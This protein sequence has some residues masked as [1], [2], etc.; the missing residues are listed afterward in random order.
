MNRA[1]ALALLRSQNPRERLEAARTLTRAA[2]QAD[3]P[4][5]REALRQ[6]RVGWIRQ[7]LEG[8]LRRAGAG[9]AP[10][11]ATA[12]I[13][14]S[15]TLEDVFSQA[16][17]ETSGLVVHE[18]GPVI[19]AARYYAEKELPDYA[20]SQT[21]SELDRLAAVLKAIDTLG[22]AAATPTTGEFELARLIDDVVSSVRA[23]VELAGPRPLLVQGDATLTELVLRNAL[24]NAAEASKDVA[25]EPDAAAILVNWGDTDLDYWVA[26]LDRGRGLPDTP[27]RLFEPGAT[28]KPEHLGMGLTVVRRATHSL[29]GSVRLQSREGGGARFEFRWPKPAVPVE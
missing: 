24:L 1:A 7:A 26:V 5:L 18:L 14:V 4:E 10:A 29:R 28:T 16:I 12:E 13:D 3:L 15:Q 6:E 25:A 8:A 21:K 19:G 11:P 23:R 17:E 22:R 9:K 27:D 2:E 20:A